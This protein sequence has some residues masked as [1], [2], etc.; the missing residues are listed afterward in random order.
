MKVNNTKTKVPTGMKLNEKDYMNSLLS[1]LKDIEKNYTVALTEA[2]NEKLYNEFKKMFDKFAELQ[3]EVYEAMFKKGW[4]VLE[5]VETKKINSKL[6]TL[7]Q[8]WEDLNK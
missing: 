4:Y 6:N 1:S 7:I 5:T 2:S 3:R 8:E